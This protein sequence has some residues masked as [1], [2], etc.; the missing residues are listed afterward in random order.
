MRILQVEGG[1]KSRSLSR[2]PGE[3]AVSVRDA[4]N[5]PVRA[6]EVDKGSKN[7]VEKKSD[8]ERRKKVLEHCGNSSF[9][10]LSSK[11]VRPGSPREI[12]WSA[13]PKER[14][15]RTARAGRS[16]FF[17]FDVFS[18][19]VGTSAFFLRRL[20]VEIALI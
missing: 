1:G 13:L 14:S 6:V 15:S 20:H 16:T 4:I 5:V 10:D 2:G 18:T 3:T 17:F 12:S 8:R 11:N 19:V 9:V 7:F